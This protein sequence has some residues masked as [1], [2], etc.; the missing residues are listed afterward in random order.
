MAIDPD[1][2]LPVQQQDR[3]NGWQVL[4]YNEPLEDESRTLEIFAFCAPM[5]VA[6][7]ALATISGMSMWLVLLALPLPIFAAALYPV[8]F[9]GRSE[10]RISQKGLWAP[11][12]TMWT[13]RMRPF[14]KWSDVDCVVFRTGKI[15]SPRP[16]VIVI[17]FKSGGDLK[18]VM[19]GLKDSDLKQLLIAIQMFVP[20][21]KTN[22]PL[23][24]VEI[25]IP[26]ITKGTSL[27]SFTQ[28]WEN[29]L[30]NR[31]AATM[32]VP[33][34][35]GDTLQDGRYVI[36]SQLTFGGNSAIYLAVDTRGNKLVVKEAV[37]PQNAQPDA[38]AKAL[39]MFEREG[40]LLTQLNDPRI[41]RLIDRFVEDE[42]HYQILEYINGIDLRTF[43]KETGSP[44]EEF[45]LRWGAEIALIL[46]YLHDRQ[47]PV[48]HR[49]VSPDNIL[50]RADGSLALIDFGAANEFLGT[51]TGTVVGKQSYIAPEQFRG[52]ASPQSDIYGLG[53]TLYFLATGEDPPAMLTSHPQLLNSSLSEDF[54]ALVAHCTAIEQ[55]DR[56]NSAKA[57]YDAITELL[58]KY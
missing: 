44:P 46:I 14:R 5:L 34:A 4:R 28:M 27:H 35:A 50:E 7:I 37:L 25:N 10:L 13:M 19:S 12:S 6:C 17:S 48:I 40:S 36:R 32:F 3:E 33:L 38:K 24:K 31:Y 57:V 53:A 20:N 52:K 16:Q 22:P 43:R 39:E 41:A 49:D 2:H 18:L 15:A 1:K 47:P 54:D 11:V 9:G 56:L 29:E 26:S 21:L 51:A 8:L 58:A 30:V 23:D 42:H 45:I 55:S